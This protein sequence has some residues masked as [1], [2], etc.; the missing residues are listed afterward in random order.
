MG[1]G[2]SF[3]FGTFG[4]FELWI[5]VKRHRISRSYY[6]PVPTTDCQPIERDLDGLGGCLLVIQNFVGFCCSAVSIT[7]PILSSY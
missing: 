6:G 4:F 1:H 2:T 5:S 3:V 7:V